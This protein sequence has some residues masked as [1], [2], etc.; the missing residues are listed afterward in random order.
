MYVHKVGMVGIDLWQVKSGTI[1]DNILVS[2]SVEDAEDFLAATFSKSKDAEKRAFDD[3]E[4][5]R[6]AAE[7]EE[8]KQ[9]EEARKAAEQDDEDEDEDEVCAL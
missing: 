9:A 7:E 5:A 4:K 2:D 3:A 6:K 8:R 1:F